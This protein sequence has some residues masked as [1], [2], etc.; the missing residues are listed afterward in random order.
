MTGTSACL[1]MFIAMAR[2]AHA[3][4]NSADAGVPHSDTTAPAAP[5]PLLDEL[6]RQTQ[7]LFQSVRPGLVRVELPP[8]KWVQLLSD[9]DNPVQKWG[10]LLSPDVMEKL[11]ASEGHAAGVE[12][13]VATQPA[14]QEQAPQH[15]SVAPPESLQRQF[16]PSTNTSQPSASA[17]DEPGDE[18]GPARTPHTFVVMRPDGGL[19]FVTG[20][21]PPY[22]ANSTA[23]SGPQFLGIVLD[24]AGHVLI[25]IFVEKDALQGRPL[26]VLDSQGKSV[27]ARFVGSDRQ[28]NLTV[29]QLDPPTGKPVTL[30]GDPPSEGSLVMLLSPNGDS[31]HL[32]IWTGGLLDRGLLVETNGH[33]GGFVRMG[34]FLSGDAMRPIA[35]ELIR[36]GKV[37]RAALGVL[38]S[39]AQTPDGHRAVRIEEVID[40]SAAAQAGLREGDFILSLAGSPVGDVPS[41]AAAI[42]QGNGQTELQLLRDGQPMTVTVNLQRR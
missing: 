38:I 18:P 15:P 4:P 26:N 33:V 30:S 12:A 20:G 28:T 14:T 31:G 39:Q 3:D 36:Y 23:K 40:H 21:A 32:S 2:P 24:D 19:E 13:F 29:I 42:A 5:A 41:F 6:S 37:R 16:S 25:P 27:Q 22:D 17:S 7:N 35:R 9:A 1:L 8:P 10:G 34:Q 11:R